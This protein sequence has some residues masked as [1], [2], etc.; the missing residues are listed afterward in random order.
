[1]E[2]NEEILE[3]FS[4]F[5]IKVDDGICYL[6]A[7]YYGYKPSYIPEEF[8]ERIL[9]TTIFE[10]R[11]GNIHWNAPLFKNQETT[12]DWVKTE[13]VEMFKNANSERGGH[14]RETTS[15]MKALFAKTPDIRKDDVLSATRMYLLNTDSK[16]IRFPHYFIEKGS[17]ATKTF[18]ILT[19]IEKFKDTQERS[20]GRNSITNTMQ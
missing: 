11:D 13:Y 3:I 9:E 16:Y 10:D 20:Y 1:M 15:R 19:W 18:D 17:G 6:M 7:V 2:I 8:K 12:F 4:E 14:V 5:R